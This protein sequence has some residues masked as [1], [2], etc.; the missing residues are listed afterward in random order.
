MKFIQ[1]STQEREHN[2]G[3]DKKVLRSWEQ[4]NKLQ[5]IVIPARE[6]AKSHYHKIQTE[7]FYFLTDNW[8]WIV[9]GEKIFPKKWDILL[10]EPND[11]HIVINKTD[12]TYSYLAFKLNYVDN[13]L[14]WD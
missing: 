1:S 4:W 5:E 10:I 11:K 6:T 3:Y 9:N 2:A 7:I 8:Y 14:Y 12:D 13:D